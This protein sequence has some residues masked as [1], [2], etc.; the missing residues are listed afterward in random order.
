M[1]LYIPFFAPFLVK[2]KYA[3]ITCIN[4]WITSVLALRLD[5]LLPLSTARAEGYPSA[6]LVH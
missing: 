1:W 5:N 2:I 6:V 4:T 3:W